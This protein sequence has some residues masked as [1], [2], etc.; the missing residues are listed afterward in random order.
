MIAA[1]LSRFT[2]WKTDQ[3]KKADSLVDF[4]LGG[5]VTT[6]GIMNGLL[7]EIE[8]L[9]PSWRIYFIQKIRSRISDAAADE[10]WRRLSE[11]GRRS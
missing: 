2:S 9:P 11:R 7:S 5:G 10:I 8:E 6:V 1:I 4:V 3:K